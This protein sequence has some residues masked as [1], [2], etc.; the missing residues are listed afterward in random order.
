MRTSHVLAD[1][2]SA[3]YESA[4]YFRDNDGKM[5]GRCLFCRDWIPLK[6]EGESCRAGIRLTVGLKYSVKLPEDPEV[7]SAMLIADPDTADGTTP[8]WYVYEC[9]AGQGGKL[10]LPK[11]MRVVAV[12]REHALGLWDGIADTIPFDEMI[13][14]RE[15][16]DIFRAPA[17][18]DHDD[19]L[20]RHGR[21]PYTILV[22]PG[23]PGFDTSRVVSIPGATCDVCGEPVS[24]TP[25]GTVCTQ[26]HGGAPY[27]TR[28]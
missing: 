6:D 21:V 28:L 23:G 15:V 20:D 18:V 26:G 7:Y 16:R 11:Y 12:D 19:T 5:E 14:P 24:D 4:L 2:A 9:P 22:D 27:T 8:C 10:T 1:E 17:G 25:S 13:A 3:G